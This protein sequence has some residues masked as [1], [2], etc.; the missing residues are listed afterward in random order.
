MEKSNP[1]MNPDTNPNINKAYLE[2]IYNFTRDEFFNSDGEAYFGRQILFL[3][4]S[5]G[6]GEGAPNYQ[7]ASS[8]FNIHA[9]WIHNRGFFNRVI[10]YLYKKMDTQPWRCI[11]LTGMNCNLKKDDIPEDIYVGGVYYYDGIYFGSQDGINVA[12]VFIDEVTF[13]TVPAFIKGRYWIYQS[14]A[15]DYKDS[16]KRALNVF[17]NAETRGDLYSAKNYSYNADIG[18]LGKNVFSLAP[19]IDRPTEEFYRV[20]A[21][22][23]PVENFS[24]VEKSSDLC[25]FQRGSRYDYRLETEAVPAN[26]RGGG[27]LSPRYN[28]VQ[29]EINEEQY[30]FCVNKC[31]GIDRD[32]VLFLVLKGDLNTL[33]SWLKTKKQRIYV[34]ELGALEIVST[35]KLFANEDIFVKLSFQ[36]ADNNDY[37]QSNKA[38]YG[39]LN[40]AGFDQPD[41][42]FKVLESSIYPGMIIYKSYY[43]ESCVLIDIKTPTR[44]LVLNFITQREYGA[45]AKIEL[46]SNL[47]KL[48]CRGSRICSR[49][50]KGLGCYDYLDYYGNEIPSV[51]RLALPGNNKSSLVPALNAIVD[52]NGSEN[53]N[54]SMNQINESDLNISVHSSMRHAGDRYANSIIID[55]SDD[56]NAGHEEFY[57]I[58]FR[59]KKKGTVK[60]SI[61]G[62]GKY[63]TKKHPATNSEVLMSR[64]MLCG[65]MDLFRNWSMG[66]HSTGA[67]LGQEESYWKDTENHIDDAIRYMTASVK[68]VVIQAPLVNE[69]LKQTP[70]DIFKTRLTNIIEM[71][72]CRDVIILTTLGLKDKEFGAFGEDI[73][74]NNENNNKNDSESSKISFEQY[75]LAVQEWAKSQPVSEHYNI[76]FID[77]RKYLMDF[78]YKGI[79][80]PD[81]LYINNGHPSPAANEII[82][83]MLI[84]AINFKY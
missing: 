69:W 37:D 17:C 66:G 48:N 42:D 60:I 35:E 6:W 24:V 13:T 1:S 4:D 76:T 28:G 73:S 16:E 74:G 83:D 44:Y 56:I 23:A 77:C 14:A 34:P 55:T 61:A 45:K 11:P 47:V 32:G 39:Q 67:W 78:V 53:L 52:Y 2:Y 22:N 82:A 40:K 59:Q 58:D 26:Y 36:K 72:Q 7:G 70:V 30:K 65:N 84:T 38:D 41:I 10:E 50:D 57:I 62:P 19:D 12:S 27:H 43:G 5:H 71:L 68:S 80:R 63:N 81:D 20:T 51:Y 31:G 18:L 15:D 9:P 49:C 46:L 3:G 33:P 25:A 8:G 75:S 21:Y 64:G 29:H 79:L 54:I